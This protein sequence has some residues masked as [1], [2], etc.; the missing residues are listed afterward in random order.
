MRDVLI[1]S[2]RNVLVFEFGSGKRR[3]FPF[4]VLGLGNDHKKFVVQG[5]AS[6]GIESL[7]CG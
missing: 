1:E 2:V 7:M 3:R 4:R 5:F 6:S